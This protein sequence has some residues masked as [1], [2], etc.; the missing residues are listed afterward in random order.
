MSLITEF[1]AT[2]EAIKE[3]QQRLASLQSNDGLKKELEFETKLKALMGEYSKSLRDVVALLDP[4]ASNKAAAAGKKV[5]H[6]RAARKV[7]V[8]KNPHTGETIETKGG[9]HKGLK[10]WKAKWGADTVETWVK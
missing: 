10:E 3:L 5:T 6:E 4:N 2:E 7:K 8:Y 1:R 9:N